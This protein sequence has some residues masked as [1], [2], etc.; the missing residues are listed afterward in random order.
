MGFREG[1]PQVAA[2]ARDDTT[3]TTLGRPRAWSRG[4]ASLPAPNY[5]PAPAGFPPG[6]NRKERKKERKK[7]MWWVGKER[8]GVGEAER[9]LGCAARIHT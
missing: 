7:G 1:E 9:S 3:V 5:E 2:A 6:N 8:E 4:E